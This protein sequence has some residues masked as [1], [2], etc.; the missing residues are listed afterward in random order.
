MKL[1]TAVGDRGAALPTASVALEKASTIGA[2]VAAV[3]APESMVG[4]QAERVQVAQAQLAQMPEIDAQ[5]VA[6]IK[7]ALARGEISFD[8]QKLAGLIVRHH[9]GQ[10]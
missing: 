2:A 6:E 10:A 7:A 9:G 5:R 8:P 1:T 3:T 4:A